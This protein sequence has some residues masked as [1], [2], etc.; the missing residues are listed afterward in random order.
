VIDWTDGRTDGHRTVHADRIQEIKKSTNQENLEI[1]KSRYHE[2]NKI[3][4]SRKSTTASH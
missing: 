2:I 4:K 1:K 3:K